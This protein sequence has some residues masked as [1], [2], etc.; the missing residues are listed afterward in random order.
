MEQLLSLTSVNTEL[1][2]WIIIVY[3]DY[4]FVISRHTYCIMIMGK[5]KVFSPLLDVSIQEVPNVRLRDSSKK[6]GALWSG[7][8]EDHLYFQDSW[9]HMPSWTSRLC[10]LSLQ[11]TPPLYDATAMHVPVALYWAQNDWLADP[12]DVR[13]LLKLLPNQLYNKY[14]PHW[15]HL[16]FIWGLDAATVVYDDVIAHIRGEQ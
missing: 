15:D 8:W 14:I 3:S 11:A 5:G 4:T 10:C 9:I 13:M 12:T 1:S 16:D 7:W 2:T 6:Q